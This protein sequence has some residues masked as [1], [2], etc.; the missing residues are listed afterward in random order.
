VILGL[1]RGATFQAAKRGEIPTLRIGRRLL[2]AKKKLAKML[3]G[4]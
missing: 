2:V 1:S 4:E 3:E